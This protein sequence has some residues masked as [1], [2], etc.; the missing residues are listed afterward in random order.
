MK[1]LVQLF[2]LFAVVVN[3]AM[4]QQTSLTID[5]QTPGWLSSKINY[6]DQKSVKRFKVTGYINATDLL[7]IGT[8]IEKQSLNGSDGHLDLSEANIVGDKAYDDDVLDINAFGLSYNYV[9]SGGY[10]KLGYLS[11]PLSLKESRTAFGYMRVDTLEVGGTSMHVIHPSMFSGVGYDDRYVPEGHGTNQNVRNLILREGVD[12][13]IKQSFDDGHYGKNILQTL[14]L[15]STLRYVGDY[16][17]TRCKLSKYNLPDSVEYIGQ[18]AFRGTGT[19]VDTLRL[20]AKLEQ[21]FLNAFSEYGG[22][23]GSKVVYFGPA[24]K[25]VHNL[26]GNDGVLYGDVEMHMLTKTPPS[27]ESGSTYRFDKVTLYVPKGTS[28]AYKKSSWKDCKQIIEEV[29]V[30][31]IAVKGKENMYVGETTYATAAIYPINAIN[32]NV[33]WSSSDTAVATISDKGEVHAISFGKAEISAKSEDGGFSAS[34]TLNVFEKTTKI[35]LPDSVEVAVDGKKTVAVIVYPQD[36]VDKQIIWKSSD[37]DIAYVNGEGIV[38]GVGKGVCQITATTVDNG[39]S[40]SCKVVVVQPVTGVLLDK[41]ELQMNVGKTTKLTA[42]VRPDDA[43]RK[44]VVWMSENNEVASVSSAGVVSALK[45]GEAKIVAKA[46]DDNSILD[47]CTVTVK[48]PVTGLGISDKEIILTLIGDSHKLT[49]MV[50]P[51]DASNKDVRWS[52]GNTAVAFVSDNGTVVAVGEG[53]TVVIAT[54]VD[55]GF[56]STCRVVVNTKA[57]GVDE[58]E[59]ANLSIST[60]RGEI[61]VQCQLTKDIVV[62]NVSGV[63]VYRGRDEHIFLE[64]GIYVIVVEGHRVKVVI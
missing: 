5:N 10:T 21:V 34:Y 15:P 31:R 50:M 7:F 46:A 19:M 40:A 1:K 60:T 62:Y 32:K 3:T 37:N 12:S 33:Q 61:S 20:P 64:S 6:R 42:T 51:E 38:W 36:K 25:F 55:G 27:I 43:S 26:L 57:G 63:V 22:Y 41:H 17:F 9:D 2:L 48:Q 56:A 11:L 24:V 53:E 52:T 18:N 54:T 30:E 13:V 49:A 8:L 14:S 59:L 47:Y 44:D 45:A 35:E 39:L 28:E 58:N 29:P 16:A 4:A 23:L